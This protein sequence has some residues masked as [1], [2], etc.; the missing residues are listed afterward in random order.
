MQSALKLSVKNARQ[1]ELVLSIYD[2]LWALVVL[3]FILFFKTVLESY[4][5]LISPVQWSISSV[6]FK[7]TF[8]KNVPWD[9]QEYDDKMLVRWHQYQEFIARL[10]AIFVILVSGLESVWREKH[11]KGLCYEHSF[12]NIFIK[13]LDE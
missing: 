8:N 12:C 1:M 3:W 9:L 7:N 10:P 2:I 6:I 5:N 13:T 11:A 4:F